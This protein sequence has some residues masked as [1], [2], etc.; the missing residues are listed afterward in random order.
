MSGKTTRLDKWVAERAALTRSQARRVIRSGRVTVDGVPERNAA[1]ALGPQAVVA[2][3]GAPLEAV[4]PGWVLH[5]PVGV[6]TTLEDPWGRDTLWQPFPDIDW[7]VVHP[8]GR[9]DQDTSGLLLATRHGHWTQRLLH[10]KRG[11]SRE[12]RALVSP[13]PTPELEKVLADGVETS[14]G[15]FSAR[16]IE[17][18]GDVVVVEVNEGKHRMVRRMLHNAG[19]SVVELHRVRFGQ[20]ELGDLP[21]GAKRPLTPAELE[22]IES[23]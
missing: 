21:V 17:L 9:L 23:V 8:V 11:V 19:H 4:E 1:L 20:I 5:K 6:L 16:V 15:V 10:P 13:T 22:W 7:G 12:Y 3:D 18:Q 14:L 2:F